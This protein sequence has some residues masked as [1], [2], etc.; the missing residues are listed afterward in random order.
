M[1]AETC[2]GG[3]GAGAGYVDVALLLPKAPTSW[4]I[5]PPLQGAEYRLRVSGQ[6]YAQKRCVLGSHYKD[7][8]LVETK[9]LYSGYLEYSG[10]HETNGVTGNDGQADTQAPCTDERWRGLIVRA[11][12]RDGDQPRWAGRRSVSVSRRGRS[13]L[14]NV[15]FMLYNSPTT[16]SAERDGRSE[17]D[18]R[19][20]AGQG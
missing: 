14:Y 2:F 8:S 15:G 11:A 13:S 10:S 16:E 7:K 6:V 4:R 17:P 3:A 19:C 1:D 5:H 9:G 18:R 12:R 20:P